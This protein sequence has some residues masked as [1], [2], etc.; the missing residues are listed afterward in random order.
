MNS[1]REESEREIE[2]NREGEREREREP[3]AQ[4]PLYIALI[5][6]AHMQPNNVNCWHIHTLFFQP[7]YN[8]V[9]HLLLCILSFLSWLHPYICPFLRSSDHLSTCI[10]GRLE[11]VQVAQQCDMFCPIVQRKRIRRRYLSQS[12]KVV[13]ERKSTQVDSVTTFSTR[14]YGL[15]VN[16]QIPPQT[17]YDATQTLYPL[18]VTSLVHNS[19]R[20]TYTQLS[21][22]P[23][24]HTHTLPDD[25]V[26]VKQISFDAELYINSAVNQSEGLAERYSSLRDYDMR[27]LDVCTGTN[28][29]V[30][31][32]MV[33]CLAD[34]ESDPNKQVL[35]SSGFILSW[36]IES[37]A[38]KTLEYLPVEEFA[39]NPCSVKRWNPGAGK[40]LELRKRFFVPTAYNKTVRAFSNASV[41]SGRSLSSLAHPYLP[42]AIIH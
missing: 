29:V 26:S 31:L 25:L 37:G 14:I 21:D 36:N 13:G 4:C 12:P 34:H 41:F 24:R 32:I 10:L 38:A 20:L 19:L 7:P 17:R 33:L 3:T 23:Y 39:S 15:S 5:T 2:R 9:C 8:R 18:N 6:H 35:I 40:A 22:T 27:L 16:A 28:S 30:V 1:E 11:T 42:V